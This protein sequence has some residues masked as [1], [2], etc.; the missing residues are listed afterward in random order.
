MDITVEFEAVND[1]T[2]LHVTENRLEVTTDG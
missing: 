1:I 2:Y